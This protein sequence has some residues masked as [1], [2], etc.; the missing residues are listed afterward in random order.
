MR[1]PLG[2]SNLDRPN[3]ICRLTKALYGLKQA[4]RAW[5]AR[6]AT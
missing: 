5:H 4:P 2:F 6:L 1:Q 3:H